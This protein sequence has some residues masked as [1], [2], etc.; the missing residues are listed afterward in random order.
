[1]PGQ[2]QIVGV[3][4][5]PVD[6]EMVAEQAQIL[7]GDDAAAEELEQ[8]REQL[9]S[10]VLVEVLVSDAD[11]KFD[12]GDF[13]QEDPQQPRENWQAPWAVAFLSPEGER[14]LAEHAGPLPRNRANF[15]AAFYLHYWKPGQ[16]LVTSYGR[17]S[18]VPP[19]VMPE[20]LMRLVPYKL[21]D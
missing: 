10:T 3:Y 21:V 12:L 1:M 14:L 16:P 15:R 20:R 17:L 19:S 7:Y 5:L 18:T 4:A 2:A 13:A 9:E 11:A 6:Q 8:A